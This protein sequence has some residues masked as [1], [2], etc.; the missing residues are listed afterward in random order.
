[1][2]RARGALEHRERSEYRDADHME[3]R[4]WRGHGSATSTSKGYLCTDL[5]WSVDHIDCMYG[6]AMPAQSGT[7]T[8][9]VW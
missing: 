8:V 4:I 2:H 6:S 3:R 1:M 5:F 7:M 9:V